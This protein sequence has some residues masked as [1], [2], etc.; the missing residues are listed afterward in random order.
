MYFYVISYQDRVICYSH[1][2][3]AGNARCYL[4]VS[5]SSISFFVVVADLLINLLLY[6]CNLQI[7]KIKVIKLWKLLSLN[8][9]DIFKDYKYKIYGVSV[10]S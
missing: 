9:C 5:L 10:R 1:K 7:I 3:T 8:L 2:T 4:F 6:R